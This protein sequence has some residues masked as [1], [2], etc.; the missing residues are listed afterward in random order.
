[1]AREMNL[2]VVESGFLDRSG[3][4]DKST[5]PSPL[6][7]EAFLLSASAPLPEEPGKVGDDFYVY[8][9]LDRQI[10][11]VPDNSEEIQIYREK[12]LQA[13]QQQLLSSWLRHQEK[14]AKI[15]RHP[16]L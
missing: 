12:L 10:P 16:N 7:D 4:N 15:T 1:M 11:T 5:F 8:T 9:F 13:K 6:L 3:Q 14:D 2:T